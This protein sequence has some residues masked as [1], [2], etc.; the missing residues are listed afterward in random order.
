[1]GMVC[2][3][4]VSILLLLLLPVLLSAQ[5]NTTRRKQS[6]QVKFSL[7]QDG[8][9]LRAQAVSYSY[10]PF[11]V[12]VEKKE[13][14]AKPN[15][16]LLESFDSIYIT[17]GIH[18]VRDSAISAFKDQYSIR[19]FLGHPDLINPDNSYLYRLPFEEGRKV[20]VTQGWNGTISHD[21][22]ISRYAYDFELQIGD[23]VH[24]ARDGI[25]IKTVDWFTEQGGPELRNKGNRILIMHSD[26][27]IATYV[28][29]EHKGVFVSE[30][31][32]VE[33][34]QVIGSSGLTGYTSGPHLH[35]VLRK[36]R[37]ISIP[38]YFEGYAGKRLKEGKKYRVKK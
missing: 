2:V 30:G 29:L 27:T 11:E 16:F 5:P 38:M 7:K 4:R 26:G 35:F 32:M 25:V 21:D 14:D 20:K 15:S 19:Y 34:G 33:R 28:H 22:E 1:M 10:A 37:D 9:S 17:N 23:P 3:K 18:P 36:E 6:E 13:S 8:D 12:L 31:E 24:A